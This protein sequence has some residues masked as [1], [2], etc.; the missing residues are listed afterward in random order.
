LGQAERQDSADSVDR[1]VCHVNAKQIEISTYRTYVVC[2][3][4]HFRHDA[5]RR[6]GAD[7]SDTYTWPDEPPRCHNCHSRRALAMARASETR[8]LAA[9]SSPGSAP[10]PLGSPLVGSLSPSQAPTK[11][12]W[13]PLA[14]SLASPFRASGSSLASA[15]TTASPLTRHLERNKPGDVDSGGCT[16]SFH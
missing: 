15:D 3:R 14:A 7:S 1:E 11:E 8:F 4:S 9:L 16:S 10:H 2:T 5:G 13:R 6:I 12:S